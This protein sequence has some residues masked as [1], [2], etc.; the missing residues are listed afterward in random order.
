[1]RLRQLRWGDAV[2]VDALLQGLGHFD[3]V[4]GA[5]VVYVE[6]AVPALF[7]SIARLLDPCRKVKAMQRHPKQLQS[8]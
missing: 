3:I 6:E 4:V 2:H 7:D 5:D 1:M 8:S